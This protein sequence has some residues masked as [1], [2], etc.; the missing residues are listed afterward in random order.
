MNMK[1]KG[2]VAICMPEGIY[3]LGG[4]DG[5]QYLKSIEK[6]DFVSK[7][8]IYLKDMTYS[9]CYFGASPSADYRFIFT[10]GGYNGRPLNVVERYDVIENKWE[11]L[12]DMPSAKYKHQCLFVKE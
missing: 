4:F 1:R 5:V 6:Y 11:I 2:S 10:F 8:W 3:V 7:S 12:S 9:K